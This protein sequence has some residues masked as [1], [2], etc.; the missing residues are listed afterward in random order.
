MHKALMHNIG[1]KTRTEG[2]LI[3]QPNVVFVRG[4]IV[5]TA[6][7]IN[8]EAV[9]AL[10]IAYIAAYIG[11]HGYKSTFVDGAAGALNNI[12]ELN[13]YNGYRCQGLTFNE[14]LESI[15]SDTD[16]IGISAMFSGEWP[17][18]RDLINA[19]REIF[20]DALIVA[21]GE[22]ITALPEYSLND[23]PAIDLCV[24]GEGEHVFYQILEKI[25]NNKTSFSDIPGIAYINANADFVVNEG[26]TRIRDIDNIS[27]PL[28]PEGYLEQ[29]WK[30]GKSYGVQT[31]RD[32]PMMISR[33][34]PFQCTFCSSPS[35]WTTRYILRD[36]EDVISEIKHYIKIY[37][38]TAVQLY[39]L[40]A[41]VKKNWIVEFCNRMIE[42]E[43]NIKWS[44]PSGTR[45]EALDSESLLLLN[46]TGC[47]YLVYA[48]ESGSDNV[49]KAIKKKVKL[50]RLTD[51]VK[52]AKKLGLVV[53][54]NLIIGF[55]FESR[56]D[57]LSTLYY[58]LKLASYGVDEVSIN[59]FSPYPGSELFK[60]LIDGNS[61]EVSD[62]Y[63]FSLTSL[64]SDYTAFN[65]ITF[66]KTMSS[67]ELASYRILFMLMN[68]ILGYL[69]HPTRVVRTIKSVLFDKNATTVLE[70]RLKDLKI[71]IKR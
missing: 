62:E 64:N 52:I 59:I 63:F 54:T 20:S 16:V 22:H 18:V 41:V 47:N 68:Y 19:I 30:A 51:S 7:A 40:T 1:D 2:L 55:P 3:H 24:L 35:M 11:N 6:L 70:H 60:E 48:P 26:L 15:P 32:I 29:F 49:L 39:D 53:R 67:K 10:G 65:P 61:F 45:S 38:I 28:W 14:I 21:G 71:R 66:N 50:D 17:V 69:I 42:E 58:G 25:R 44:L 57:V 43:I 36:V 31:E 23:C 34:C 13:N 4:P 8:N 12:W 27:W 56:R 9:P 33:G 5:S 37:D 46:E